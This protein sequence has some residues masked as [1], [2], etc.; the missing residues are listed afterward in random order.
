MHIHNSYEVVFCW[1]K[2]CN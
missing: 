1:T 2:F